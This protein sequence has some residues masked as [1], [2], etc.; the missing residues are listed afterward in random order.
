[1]TRITRRTFFHC[2]ALTAGAVA[3]QGL[4][5]RRALAASGDAT[6]QALPGTGGYGPLAPTPSQ[7]TGEVCMALP[8][9]FSYNVLGKAGALM[10]DGNPTP[11][12]HDSMA[13]FAGNGVIRLV[14]NHEIND[15]KGRPDAA[16]GGKAPAYDRSAGGGTTTLVIDP[17]TREI[18]RDFVSLSGSLHNCAGGPT[19]WGTWITCEETT[20]GTVLM[21]DEK[22]NREYGGFDQNHGYCFEVPALADG[23][24]RIEPIKAMGRFVHEAVAVDPATSIVYET[25]DRD[26]S[27]FYRFIPVT[28]GKLADGGR[29][30]MLAVRDK[31]QYD[32]RTGQKMGVEL[33]VVWVDI[34][35][36]DPSNAHEESLAVH[37]QGFVQ[38]SAVFSRLEGC[39]YA[40]GSIFFTAT[41]GGTGQHGQIW[42]YRPAREG[43]GTLRLFFESPDKTLMQSPDNLCVSPRG[44]LVICEDSGDN[45]HV[46][47]LTPEGRVF[48]FAHDLAGIEHNGEFAGATFSPDGQ[49]LF[50]NMQRPGI[51]YAIWGP[52]RDGAL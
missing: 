21:K 45:P 29:L 24:T 35:K 38:G 48:D 6:L 10:S 15:G 22:R 12:A 37:M 41:S 47:G 52:W 50:V 20:L 33:P 28:P 49:T 17:Q 46:R 11:R 18:V 31:P 51:T 1:M 2:A 36:P 26:P 39:W 27:G 7:N 32:T 34:E 43:N 19:P 13:A 9:G 25:E 5:A 14:R 44:G 30:Q 23:P 40:G 4:S 16:I 3:L 42:E 8:K